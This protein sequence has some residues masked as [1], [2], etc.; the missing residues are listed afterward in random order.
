MNNMECQTVG[1]YQLATGLD[2]QY[3]GFLVKV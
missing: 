3:V 2:L 1:P